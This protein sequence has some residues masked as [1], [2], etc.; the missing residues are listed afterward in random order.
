MKY[1]QLI[2]D[3]LGKYPYP[4]NTFTFIAKKILEE[5][6]I[7]CN[8]PE[9]MRKNVARVVKEEDSESISPIDTQSK[10]NKTLSTT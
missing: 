6:E 10:G 5:N 3:Y 9:W 2:L 1:K 7:E 4:K 8:S